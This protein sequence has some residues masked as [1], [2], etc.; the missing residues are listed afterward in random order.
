[1]SQLQPE[2][3][4]RGLKTKSFGR[5]V[6]CFE[7][8]TST[9]D[10]ILKLAEAGC[11][12]GTVVTAEFQ[13]RG[14][15]R[16]G[17]RWVQTKGKGLAF[18]LLLR[19]KLHPDELSEITLAASVAVAKTLENFRFRPQIKWPNDLLLGGRKV[20]G[21]LTELG[22]KK[23]KMTTVILGI[24]INLNQATKDFPRE[25]RGTATSLYRF[26]GRKL[27]RARFLQVLLYQLEETFRW[28]TERRFSKVLSEWRKRSATLGQQ[29]K[30]TQAHRLFYGQVVDIDE[31]GALL[32]RNDIGITE[33]VTSGDVEALPSPLSKKG[34]L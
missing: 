11:Q 28:V 3:L 2:N 19:P 24:G 27:D 26:S 14:R 18:S 25:L 6:L 15:G 9:N 4:L 12:E 20:C 29:V 31:K 17:R 22:P 13:T 8:V 34:R 32:V 30:V 5:S 10:V 16:Q 1:L 33:R 7:K 23:D 21:I